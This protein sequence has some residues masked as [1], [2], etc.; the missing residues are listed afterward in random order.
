MQRLYPGA[1][2]VE[3]HVE[4]GR[5]A[6]F[7][8]IYKSA[9][10][11]QLL[12]IWGMHYGGASCGTMCLPYVYKTLDTPAVQPSKKT[13]REYNEYEKDL[14]RRGGWHCLCGK[15]LPHYTYSCSC[16]TNKRDI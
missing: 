14:L 1:T 7:C 8:V 2:F 12:K 6:E 11:T 15:V 9:D 5:E 10:E 13:T 4:S 16:G 3:Q